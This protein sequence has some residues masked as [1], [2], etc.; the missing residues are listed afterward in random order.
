MKW[1]N[2]A[3][4]KVMVSYFK[5]LLEIR[6]ANSVFRMSKGSEVKKTLTFSDTP[7][8]VIAYSLD[9]SGQTN[10]V[11]TIFVIH[12]SSTA[13]KTVKLPARG[14]WRVLAEGLIARAGGVRT[15]ASVE[16]ISVAP[17]STMVL[18]LGK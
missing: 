3:K 17:Q 2:R 11:K 7:A 8:D 5:G 14:A 18:T 9:A 6:K 13:P 12:N 15:T 10:S 16:T 1:S 4:N